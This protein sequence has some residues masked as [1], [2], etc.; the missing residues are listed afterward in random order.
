[1]HQEYMCFVVVKEIELKSSTAERAVID[2]IE[3][4]LSVIEQ[5]EL[6]ENKLD[7]LDPDRAIKPVGSAS[8]LNVS[9]EAGRT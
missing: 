2:L 5:P 8:R 1:M 7:W 3:K 6:Q 4:F 9:P